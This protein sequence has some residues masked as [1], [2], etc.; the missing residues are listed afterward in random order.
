MVNKDNLYGLKFNK[1]TVYEVVERKHN[2]KI[3]RCI[4][5]C[6]NETKVYRQKILNNHTKSCGCLQ[7]QKAKEQCKA[8]QKYFGPKHFIQA[9]KNMKE[10]ANNPEYPGYTKDF[11]WPYEQFKKDMLEEYLKHVEKFGEHQTTLDRIDGT[12]GY[13]KENCRWANFTIQA[14]NLKTNKL[15]EYNG[16]NK[17]FIEWKEYFNSNLDIKLIKNRYW[18]YKWNIEKACLTP[19]NKKYRGDK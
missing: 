15:I 18:N 3:Y 13:Y 1:L 16:L 6:G 7:K 14:N 9:W 2:Q 5:E 10:R 11:D 17:T 8:K 19:V 12:K 4:C